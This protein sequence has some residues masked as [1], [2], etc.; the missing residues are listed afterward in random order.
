MKKLTIGEYIHNLR[1]KKGYTLT[2]L[3]AILGIDS[4]ALSKIENGKKM[5]SPKVL[6]K[7]AQTFSLD[8]E[9]LKEEFYSEKIAQEIFQNSCREEVLRLAEEKLRYIKFK[10]TQQKKIKF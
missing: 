7:V 5:L 10:M 9:E 8:L 4:G 6:P 3:G 2:Q 1:L